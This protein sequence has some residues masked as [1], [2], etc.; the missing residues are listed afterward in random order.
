MFNKFKCT[1]TNF[2]EKEFTILMNSYKV[3]LVKRN[4]L[5]YYL[6]ATSD[7]D[8]FGDRTYTYLDRVD[9]YYKKSINYKFKKGRKTIKVYTRQSISDNN[10][11][12]ILYE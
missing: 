3:R 6:Y 10:I 11:N 12:D 2:I 4:G 8:Y 9:G 5:W 1:D 7:Y